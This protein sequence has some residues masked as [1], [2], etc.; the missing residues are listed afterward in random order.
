MFQRIDIGQ[1]LLLLHI[2]LPLLSSEYTPVEGALEIPS[3]ST[4][5]A[6]FDF[7]DVE[8]TAKAIDAGFRHVQLAMAYGS[9]DKPREIIAKTSVPR[10]ELFVTVKVGYLPES[11]DLPGILNWLIPESKRNFVPGRPVHLYQKGNEISGIKHTLNSVGLQYADLC[12]M[13]TPFTTMIEAYGM[14]LP[15]FV[16]HWFAYYPI[17]SVLR[18]MSLFFGTT[19]HAA[20]AQRRR[21]WLAL[22][23][24]KRQGLCRHLGV[25]IFPA[26]YVHELDTYR[27][28]P[29]AAHYN[30]FH[31]LDEQT[32]PLMEHAKRNNVRLIS[33]GAR[34]A[35]G[36]KTLLAIAERLG[37]TVFHV[38]QWWM[39]QHGMVFDQFS[40]NW[41]I[42]LTQIPEAMTPT[43]TLS[44]EDM[45]LIDGIT[46]RAR[47]VFDYGVLP[48]P[49]Y[50]SER[51]EL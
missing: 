26:E 27:T 13:H 20:A 31:P 46:T 47:E 3:C 42:A 11:M 44:K 16:T 38:L 22:E 39:M 2:W 7:I 1:A 43:Q 24:A 15:W 6:E 8:D 17:R 28:E 37:V 4:T 14:M 23:E 48:P 35:A 29:L 32:R 25:G 21:S 5:L 18:T 40:Y 12:M 51:T 41:S 34:Y 10:D 49:Y 19:S 33:F 30:A 50:G 36:D 45:A 9:M